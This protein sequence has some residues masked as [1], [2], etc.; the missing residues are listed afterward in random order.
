MAEQYKLGV[1]CRTHFVWDVPV[2]SVQ[3]EELSLQILHVVEQTLGHPGPFDL[4]MLVGA[5][6]GTQLECTCDQHYDS[7]HE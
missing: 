7:D 1:V 3:M 5:D 4:H 6:D 2:T